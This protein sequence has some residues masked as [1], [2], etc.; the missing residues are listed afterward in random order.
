[1]APEPY[2]L[3]LALFW[4]DYHCQWLQIYQ[5][6]LRFYF[7]LSDSCWLGKYC[8]SCFTRKKEGAVWH[9]LLQ[10]AVAIGYQLA[11]PNQWCAPVNI[12]IISLGSYQ[13]WLPVFTEWPIC[14][15]GKIMSRGGLRYLF[16]A[17]LYVGIGLTSILSP[18]TDGHLQF[19]FGNLF[20]DAGNVQY[21]DGLFFD[22][23][24]ENI[25]CVGKFVLTYLLFC[26]LYSSRK[27]GAL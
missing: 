26:S 13:L 4:P 8:S 3:V 27:S 21:R 22:N 25:G 23:D 17:V 20:D 1:M 14:F 7:A 2:S 6:G 10:I 9:G 16:D 5:A 12:V 11:Q 24:R 15:I 18:A 19:W